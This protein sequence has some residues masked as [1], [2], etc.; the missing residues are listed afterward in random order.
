[1][2]IQPH[3][4]PGAQP[5]SFQRSH[6]ETLMA[7]HFF[8]SEKADGIRCLLYTEKTAHGYHSFLNGHRKVRFLLFDLV[9]L[10]GDNVTQRPYDIRLGKLR[11]L[12]LKPYIKY[13]SFLDNTPDGK[14]RKPTFSVELKPLQLA[15]H[16]AKVFEDM[17][18]VHHGTDG[19]IF[20]SKSS[21]Y[22]IGTCQTMIKWKP[23]EENTV[24]FRIEIIH[25]S[26]GPQ[27]L[28]QTLQSSDG[29]G[30]KYQ[31]HGSLTLEPEMAKSWLENP[32]KGRIAECRYDPSW[33]GTWRFMRWR[34]DKSEPNYIKTF[35]SVMESIRHAVS[36]D[37]VRS[38]CVVKKRILF[39]IAK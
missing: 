21:A 18:N 6:I 11:D 8:V 12:V 28:L 39:F 29:K 30:P 32:P 2:N 16:T 36:K 38:L 34:D 4:F 37:E 10:D 22:A 3:R 5:V 9:V 20:T 19:V 13:M 31:L 25:N 7:E 15:Y 24:D 33:P 35:E 17:L 23:A 27:Y 1:M 14:K 26:N